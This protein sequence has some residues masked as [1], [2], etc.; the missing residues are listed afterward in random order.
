MSNKEY[1][2]DITKVITRTGE[3][4]GLCFQHDRWLEYRTKWE[5]NPKMGILEKLPLQ[6]D[7]WASDVC[8]L[9]CPMCVRNQSGHKSGFMP[10]EIIEKVL[11]EAKDKGLYAF[12]LGGL[13]EPML[14]PKFFDYIIKAKAAGVVDVNVHTNGTRLEPNANRLII[15]SGLDRLIV[16][17]DAVT[18][19]T[20]EKIR[21]GASFDKVYAGLKDL[22]K[23]KTD[24][25]SSTPDIKLNIIDMGD[26]DEIK[27]FI[28]YWQSQV[29]RISILP[30]VEFDENGRELAKDYANRQYPDN[31]VCAWLWQRLSVMRDG[32]VH[33]CF[34]DIS[35]RSEIVGDLAT[36]SI[37][38]IWQGE[39]MTALR[40]LHLAGKYRECGMCEYCPNAAAD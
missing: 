7:V 24:S 14:L 6:I 25:K 5:E 26:A 23:Q 40:K 36:Q 8:N 19:E 2:W 29:D 3:K 21:I 15:E 16:S 13:G 17:L 22:I 1:K 33:A 35:V 12:N 38:E 39:K 30:F 11:A 9:K 18:K 4:D 37:E 32:K 31:F 10:P 28:D 34:R 27:Q 20:Y